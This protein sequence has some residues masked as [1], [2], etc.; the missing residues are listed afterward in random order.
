MRNIIVILWGLIFLTGNASIG[1]SRTYEKWYQDRY[2]DGIKEYRLSDRTRVDCLTQ[3]HAIE[4]DFGYKWA[5]ALGQ[6][7]HYALKTGRKPGIVLILKQEDFKYLDRLKNLTA[8]YH[9][10]VK[11]WVIKLKE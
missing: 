6:S 5:E 2:C 1:F 4:F 11:I 8:F 7:L 9:L 3:T 10:P